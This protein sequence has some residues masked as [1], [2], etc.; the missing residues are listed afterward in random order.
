MV[1]HPRLP[2]IAGLDSG[3]PAVHIWDGGAGELRELGSVGAGSEAYDDAFGWNRH[4][5]TPA[6]AW[7][8]VQPLLMVANEDGVV[9]WTPA[10]LFDLEGPPPTADCR[11]LAFSPDGRTLWASPSSGGDDDAW[12]RSDAIDLASG[13][14]TTGPRWDTGVAE[15]PG[16]GLVVTLSSDQGA[17]HGLFA[18]VDQETTPAAMRVLRRA[19][20]LDADG[21]ETPVFSSD[22]RHFA[23]R[24]NAYGNS[25]AVFEFPSLRRVL[26]TTLGEPSPGYPYPPEWLAQQR[27]WSPHNTAFG[28]RPG[29]L[30]VGTPAGTLVEIDLEAQ[31][32][33][34]HDVLSGSRVSALSTTSAGEL[35]VAGSGGELALLTVRSGTLKSPDKRGDTATSAVT[36][37][38]AFL[39]ATSEVPDDGDPEPHLVVTD[40]ARDWEPDDLATVATASETDPTWLRLR[41][42]I[43]SVDPAP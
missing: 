31:H 42:A 21:Y 24:G 5:R 12:E 14:V 32:A 4:K 38:T 35:V 34:E 22:G 33:V 3:R 17:T 23:V 41:A 37:V 39:E 1:C 26:S 36:A 9:R 8:P 2:L 11:S 10:G 29:V 7:H 20:I 18:R 16:G 40:G 13:T 6:M 27:A 28:S 15:H 25:L 30:W 43:N 19:L